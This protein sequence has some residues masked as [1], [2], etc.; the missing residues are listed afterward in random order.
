MKKQRIS[1]ITYKKSNNQLS[2]LISDGVAPIDFLKN[3]IDEYKFDI[4]YIGC[5][6]P[7][8]LSLKESMQLVKGMK[9]DHVQACLKGKF[10]WIN[11]DEVNKL[12]KKDWFTLE[13]SAIILTKQDIDENFECISLPE[14]SGFN[15]D[16]I[17]Q[18]DTYYLNSILYSN[19][20][21]VRND[22]H[23]TLLASKDI[24]ILHMIE[25]SLEDLKKANNGSF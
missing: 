10:L 16:K 8:L 24:E 3:V 1:Y 14:L 2:Y 22:F 18:K 21:Y 19:D 17:S 23:E 4:L 15:K 20:V 9:A 7:S 25:N 13:G 12:Y 5:D 11:Y 6:G